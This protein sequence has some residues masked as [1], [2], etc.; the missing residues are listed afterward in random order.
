MADGRGGQVDQ[1]TVIVFVPRFRDGL[2]FIDSGIQSSAEQQQIVSEVK[3]TLFG[4]DPASV[5]NAFKTCSWGKM[6]LVP[7]PKGNVF[8][9]NIP[10]VCR[11]Y[12]RECFGA[13]Y[14]ITKDF[15]AGEWTDD[16]WMGTCTCAANVILT[17]YMI[18]PC[19]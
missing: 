15:K 1:R 6:E 8:P 3:E 7:S 4:D 16:E 5:H 9:V 10:S 14:D 2:T 17:H 13:T 11:P 19:P 18:H 12:F